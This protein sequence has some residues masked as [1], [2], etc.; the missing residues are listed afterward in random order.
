MNTRMQFLEHEL[1]LN[2]RAQQKKS[3]AQAS[4]PVSGS[5]EAPASS[6]QMVKLEHKVLELEAMIRGLT[7]EMLDL[8]TVTRKLASALEKQ[9]GNQQQGAAQVPPRTAVRRPVPEQP[10]EEIPSPAV[11]RPGLQQPPAAGAASVRPEKRSFSAPGAQIPQHEREWVSRETPAPGYQP[12]PEAKPAP[13]E[14]PAEETAP[15]KPG[16]FEFVMQPDGTIL[17]R[18]KKTQGNVIIAGT[19]YGKG[20]LSRSSA[21]RAESDAVIEAVEDDTVEIK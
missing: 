8:K 7:E 9:G 20:H 11:G 1:A 19:G 12:V 10:A 6:D 2:E 3:S 13:A 5:A 14:V 17:K 15:L 21:I 4:S 16:E 18:P